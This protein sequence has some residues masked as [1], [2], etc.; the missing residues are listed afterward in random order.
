MARLEA[1][2]Q[3]VNSGRAAGAVLEQAIQAGLGEAEEQA[4]PS[5]DITVE[6]DLDEQ[7][8]IPDPSE[9]S[10]RPVESE[11]APP[12][13]RANL[14][15]LFRPTAAVDVPAPLPPRTR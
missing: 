1:L 15:P 7:T 14:Y 10:A 13:R 12:E 9:P 2:T 3:D 5:G 6:R 8:R 11:S 4:R